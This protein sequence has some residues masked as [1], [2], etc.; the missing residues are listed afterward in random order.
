MEVIFQ[1]IEPRLVLLGYQLVVSLLLLVM[2]VVCISRLLAELYDFLQA[3][4]E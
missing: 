3:K 4:Q 1:A 2:E